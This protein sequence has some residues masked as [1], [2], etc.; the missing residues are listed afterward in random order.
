VQ[1][2]PS[3]PPS[4]AVLVA[5]RT[6]SRRDRGPLSTTARWS[7]VYPSA[8]SSSHLANRTSGF[9]STISRTEASGSLP[10][11]AAVSSPSRAAKSPVVALVVVVVVVVLSICDE[12]S[13]VKASKVSILSVHRFGLVFFVSFSGSKRS[14]CASRTQRTAPS[15]VDECMAV[16][17]KSALLFAIQW[18]KSENDGLLEIQWIK[19]ED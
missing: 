13:R 2:P 17:W 10:R 6:V 5:S 9:A 14:A 18:I 8:S 15:M 4:R 1:L 19:S 7:G 12:S 3:F 16:P 11:N